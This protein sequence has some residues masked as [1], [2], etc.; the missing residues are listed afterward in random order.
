MSSVKEHHK[1]HYAGMQKIHQKA[2][3]AH[4]SEMENHDEDSPEHTLHKMEATHHSQVADHYGDMLEDCEK[5]MNDS[6]LSKL[7]PD[8]VR[9]VIPVAPAPYGSAL[10]LTAV[11]R[12]GAPVLK[13]KPN[14]PVEL[15]HFVKITDD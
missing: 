14:V 10:G 8:S 3:A 2:A 9:S 1:L 15:E 13:E 6:D 5:A 12:A 7:V 11:P 4:E